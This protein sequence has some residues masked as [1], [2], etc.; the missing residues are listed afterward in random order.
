MNQEWRTMS[1]ATRYGSHS[2][3]DRRSVQRNKKRSRAVA[4]IVAGHGSRGP[5]G[6]IGWYRLHGSG[7]NFGDSSC[8]N[9][10][11]ASGARR[12]FEQALHA[13]RQKASTPQ[14]GHAYAN[15]SKFGGQAK[16][17]LHTAVSPYQQ[18]CTGMMRRRDLIRGPS[19]LT[20][21]LT[22]R[23]LPAD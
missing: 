19:K 17:I 6:S 11:H 9:S 23:H 13:E 5:T 16:G 4:L 2:A 8:R 7:N 12:V 3:H 10:G 18:F 22:N 14:C 15:S 1:L 21:I 20:H